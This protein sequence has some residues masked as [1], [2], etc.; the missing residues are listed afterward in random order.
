M[1][2]ISE[3][4][5]AYGSWVMTVRGMDG[6]WYG[7]FLRSADGSVYRLDRRPVILADAGV[8]FSYLRCMARFFDE[9][10][11]DDAVAVRYDGWLGSFDHACLTLERKERGYAH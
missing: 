9:W 8:I 5:R 2:R 10:Y 1:G 7:G 3:E 11:G 4:R 6:R